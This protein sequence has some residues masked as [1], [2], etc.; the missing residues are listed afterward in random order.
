MLRKMYNRQKFISDVNVFSSFRHE[1]RR[2]TFCKPLSLK[3][4]KIPSGFEVA[5]SYYSRS[6]RHVL[7]G[8]HYQ[9]PPREHAKI[10]HVV[11]GRA[12]DVV[13]DI[14]RES[15]TYG[16]Y[17]VMELG[18]RCDTVYIPVGCAHGFMTVKNNTL[19]LY[20][21]TSVHSDELDAGVRWDSFGYSWEGIKEP[22]LSDRDKNLP[23]FDKINSPF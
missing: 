3:N 21:Q 11:S 14:R 5:E 12:I 2:G 1:D 8:M 7:R 16:D 17:K 13:L 22:T 4:A 18:D 23:P 19:M 6:K 15:N 20:Y 9:K 10:V